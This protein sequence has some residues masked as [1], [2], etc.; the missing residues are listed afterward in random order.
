[1]SESKPIHRQSA[2]SGRTSYADP[3]V[4]RSTKQGLFEVLLQFIKHTS[5]PDEVAP[6]FLL[7][8][9]TSNG[10]YKMGFPT[11]F[12]LTHAE[13]IALKRVLED[14]LALA[15]ESADG[16]YLVLRLDQQ[17]TDLAGHDPQ[18]VGAA[19]I[20]LLSSNDVLDAVMD[21]PEV[22]ALA[23]RAQGAL[24]V[25]ELTD[26]IGELEG[27]LNRGV[28]DEQA[29]QVWTEQHSWVFGNIYAVRDSVRSI[30]LGDSLDHLLPS[31]ATGLR[32]IFELKRPDMDVLGY[33][34]THK[35]FFWSRHTSQAIGQCHRY[36]DA[37]HE[38]AANGLRDNPEVVAYHP[39]AAIVIGR[40]HDWQM[41]RTKALHGLNARLHGVQVMTYDHLL[42]QTKR[43]LDI[44]KGTA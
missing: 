9:K 22:L 2:R 12:T 38:F 35:S 18:A 21:A 44:L 33:D 28:A 4:I 25:Q 19:L 29:Y 24:R 43:M 6:K 41:E 1:M 36:L 17:A 31:T 13:T 20:R 27:M 30:A 14:G 37:L 5:R 23:Q 8:K 11:E 34:G 26:A 7:W 32:D 16:D 42:A 10:Q 15:D 3:V 39:R 40:S